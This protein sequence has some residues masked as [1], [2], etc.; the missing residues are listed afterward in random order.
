MVRIACPKCHNLTLAPHCVSPACL[1]S[2]VTCTHCGLVLRCEDGETAYPMPA[3]TDPEHGARL[4]GGLSDWVRAAD[5]A[6]AAA[7]AEVTAQIERLDHLVRDLH[8]LAPT[9]KRAAAHYGAGIQYAICAVLTVDLWCTARFLAGDVDATTRMY[10]AREEPFAG[11]RH[12]AAALFGAEGHAPIGMGSA[13]PTGGH[14][15]P[16]PAGAARS[17]SRN[18]LRVANRIDAVKAIQGAAVTIGGHRQP[19]PAPWLRLFEL[20]TYGQQ[21]PGGARRVRRGELLLAV[22]PL[23]TAEALATVRREYGADPV[24]P[25]TPTHAGK[26]LALVRRVVEDEMRR[27]QL[28]PER[29]RKRPRD[30]HHQQAITPSDWMAPA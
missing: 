13:I 17:D 24:I 23:T 30:A 2:S 22:E 4:P 9:A 16:P 7:R 11:L 18:E 5:T 6:H 1:C 20:V 27:R 25:T 26:V 10:V 28:I 14:A 3:N 8:D 19:I 15:A 21:R 29:K 12:V